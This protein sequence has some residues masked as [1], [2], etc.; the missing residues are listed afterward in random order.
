MLENK[1]PADKDKGRLMAVL[2]HLNQFE[3]LG[4]SRPKAAIR[5][6]YFCS[7]ITPLERYLLFHMQLTWPLNYAPPGIAL[8]HLV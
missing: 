8:F 4:A 5:K 6:G 1:R 3:Q 2:S 7:K